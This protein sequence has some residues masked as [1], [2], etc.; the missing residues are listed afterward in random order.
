MDLAELRFRRLLVPNGFGHRFDGIAMPFRRGP[1][2][3]AGGGCRAVDDR[4]RDAPNGKRFQNV[5]FHGIPVFVDGAFVVVVSGCR[6]TDAL[7]RGFGCREPVQEPDDSIVEQK[8][9]HERGGV[10]KEAQN[11]DERRG[12]VDDPENGVG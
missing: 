12:W 2:G 10:G 9:D 6:L 11:G 5:S 4:S 1:L 3:C 7:R 8:P